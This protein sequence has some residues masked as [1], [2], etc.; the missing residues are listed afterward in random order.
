MLV[1]PPELAGFKRVAMSDP[2]PVYFGAEGILLVLLD[3][4]GAACQAEPLL[5]FVHGKG[6][7]SVVVFDCLC[8]LAAKQKRIESG[9]RGKGTFCRGRVSRSCT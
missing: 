8:S 2:H 3:A 9:N 6:Q 5:Q 4:V 1:P 7:Q